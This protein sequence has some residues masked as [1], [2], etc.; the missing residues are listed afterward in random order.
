M[1]VSL[2]QLSRRSVG[3]SISQLSSTSSRASIAP[4]LSWARSALPATSRGFTP[5][6]SSTTTYSCCSLLQS[7]QKPRFVSSTSC[8]PSN[9][10]RHNSDQPGPKFRQWEFDD[11]TAALPSSTQSP[12][13]NPVILVDV[14]EPSELSSTGVIPTAVNIPFA[15][16]G[17][18][19]YLAEDEF[20]TRFGFPKPI[21]S[22]DQQIIF[23]CKAKAGCAGTLCGADGCAGWLQPGPSGCVPRELVGLGEER[24]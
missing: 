16:Q 22:P 19:L 13:H 18:A 9:Q 15:S 2:R 5:S 24:R 20:E 8:S 10:L 3:T 4:T 14:R 12:S 11:I 23:Y 1:A 21:P 7:Q 6:S 17:D